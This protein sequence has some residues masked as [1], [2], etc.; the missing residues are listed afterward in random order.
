MHA[1]KTDS[2]SSVV[3]RYVIEDELR[4]KHVMA[5]F[6]QTMRLLQG[7]YLFTPNNKSPVPRL[8]TV[9]TTLLAQARLP[10][11]S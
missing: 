9:R 3:P 6:T 10:P 4:S 2:G 5:P 8:I 11:E 1:K 7:H